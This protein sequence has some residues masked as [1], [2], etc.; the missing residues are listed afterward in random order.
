MQN[1]RIKL[2]CFEDCYTLAQRMVR[3]QGGQR[4]RIARTRV[5]TR[6]STTVIHYRVTS[7]VLTE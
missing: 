5:H 4:L 7:T 1:I 2:S 6:G 3:G